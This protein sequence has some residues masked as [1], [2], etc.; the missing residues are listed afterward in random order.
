MST[1]DFSIGELAEAVGV[2][3]STLR[4]YERQGILKPTG[5]TGA[6]YRV[7]DESSL[8]R[9]RFIRAAQASGFTLDDIQMLLSLRDGE[10]APCAEVQDLVEARLDGVEERLRDLRGV[11]AVLRDSLRLCKEREASGECHVLETLERSA[12]SAS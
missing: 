7:Y 9:L 3:T 8:E 2:P 4:Y 10:T 1:G 11:R 5:R 12:Q 6:N